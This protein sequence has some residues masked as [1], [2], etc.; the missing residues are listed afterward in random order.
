MSGLL[1]EIADTVKVAEDISGSIRV[2][3]NRQRNS[4]FTRPFAG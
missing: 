2:G 3:G 4:R 1:G